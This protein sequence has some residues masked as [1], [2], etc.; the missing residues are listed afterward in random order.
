MLQ[1]P[2]LPQP[3]AATPGLACASTSLSGH[4]ALLLQVPGSSHMCPCLP[5]PLSPDLQ[6]CLDTPLQPCRCP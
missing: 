3:P 4:K 2:P 6:P 1:C 5:V